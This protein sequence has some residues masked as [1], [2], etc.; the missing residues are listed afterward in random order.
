MDQELLISSSSRDCRGYPAPDLET[1][2]FKFRRHLSDHSLMDH[3]ILDH[4]AAP[5]HLGSTGLEL[6]FDEQ[7]HPAAGDHHTVKC[8]Q[9]EPQGNE[10]QI[11]DQRVHRSPDLVVVQV[12]NVAPFHHHDSGISTQPIVELPMT[13]IDGH[14]FTRSSLEHA[15]GE[16]SCGRAGIQDSK[17]RR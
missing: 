3:R 13:D 4:P 9:N 15:I 12:A 6:R 14:H 8:S 7:H 11:G 2:T 17:T 1:V 16:T 10:R 5:V